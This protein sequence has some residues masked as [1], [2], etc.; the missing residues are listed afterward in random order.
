MR[1]PLA[2]VLLV[3]ALA[4]PGCRFLHPQPDPTPEEGAWGR[5]RNRY[6]ARANLYD[7]FTTR[8]FATAVYEGPE[9]RVARLARVASWK[10]V[11]KE[12][13]ERMLAEE[14][15]QLARWDEFLVTFFTTDRPDNDLDT[16]RSI[17]RVSLEPV[18]EPGE[19]LAASIEQIRPDATL[20]TLY[21]NIDDFD[22]VYRVRFPRWQGEPLSGRP[23]TLKIASARGRLELEFTP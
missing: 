15:A 3:A 11:G 21:P 1:R 12:E 20:R 9:V 18:G 23:F 10:G 4:L 19:A 5:A 13:R 7:G 17:W 6:T 22:T 14:Q 8:A 2:A 16:P